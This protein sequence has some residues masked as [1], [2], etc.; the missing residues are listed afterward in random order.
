[1]QVNTYIEQRPSEEVIA[2]AALSAF[3]NIAEKWQLTREEE[4]VLLGDPARSTFF[5]WRKDKNGSLTHD[6]LERISYV[7]G[8]YK[9]LRILLPDEQ[10][11]NAWIKKPNYTYPFNGQTALEK[12]LAG[13]VV[14]LADVRRYL[15]AERG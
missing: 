3:F 1:M 13:N 14:D 12:M 15:D 5:K 11:A 8:I 7:M 10:A 6:V 9:A 2:R 4:Q